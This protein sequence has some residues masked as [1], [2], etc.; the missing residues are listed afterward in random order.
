MVRR[1]LALGAP[2]AVTRRYDDGA[3]AVDGNTED[4]VDR[5]EADGVVEGQPQVARHLAQYPALPGKQIQ[6]VDGHRRRSD[7]E[8]ADGQRRDEV[9]RRLTQGALKEERQQDD[10]VPADCRKADAGRQQ[11]H[12]RRQ[13]RSPRTVD[14]AVVPA[15]R[16]AGD[17]DCVTSGNVVGPRDV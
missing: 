14:V 3:E 16:R 6:R 11:P 5:T 8:V 2:L 7:D 1:Y 9:V 12:R 10:Q 13:P 17:D 15:R 4:G